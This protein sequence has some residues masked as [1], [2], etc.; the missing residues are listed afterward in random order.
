MSAAVATYSESRE[1]IALPSGRTSRRFITDLTPDSR[2][3][4]RLPQCKPWGGRNVHMKIRARD[5][6]SAWSNPS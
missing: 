5:C 3:M 2:L 1:R 4:P 6:P